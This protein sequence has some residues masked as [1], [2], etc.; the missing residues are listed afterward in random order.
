[1]QYVYTT[2]LAGYLVLINRM[3]VQAKS[4]TS[5]ISLV[6]SAQ[7]FSAL[8]IHIMNMT[9]MSIVISTILHDSPRNVQDVTV[10]S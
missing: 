5:N 3:Y 2:R 7:L 8:K 9:G 4:S 1:M 6:Q 10:Q